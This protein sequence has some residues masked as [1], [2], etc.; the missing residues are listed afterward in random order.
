MKE[1]DI[2]KVLENLGEKVSILAEENRK[3]KNRDDTGR[4]LITLLG[5]YLTQDDWIELY[6]ST[7]DRYIKELILDWGSHFFPKDFKK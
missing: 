2:Q 1:Q 6:R 4:H 5:N 3:C 7:N